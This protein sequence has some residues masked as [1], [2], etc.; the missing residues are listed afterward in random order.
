MAGAVPPAAAAA[1]R[2]WVEDLV[3]SRSSPRWSPPSSGVPPSAVLPAAGVRLHRMDADAAARAPASTASSPFVPEEE[4]QV[5][6]GTVYRTARGRVEELVRP[7]SRSQQATV[8]P[9]CP[10]WTVRDLVA[11]L[12]GVAADRVA[13]R[14]EGWGTDEWTAAQVSERRG[15]SVEELL[16]EWGAV[17]APLE[18]TLSADGRGG[19]R[20]V[21]DAVT[22]EHDLRGALH[23]PPEVGLEDEAYAL[24]FRSYLAALGERAT[25]AGLAPLVVVTADGPFPVGDGEHPVTARTTRHE[26]FRA[27]AGRRSEHQVRAWRWSADADPWLDVMNQFGPLPEIDVRE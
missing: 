14:R 8:V 18:T 23:L 20:L 1:R 9:G 3:P 19:R 26:L 4:D 2:G 17:A 10:H 6:V 25:A 7:L 11:H 22:H 24:A 16:G 5:D 15:R 21:I 12:T 13:G 27:L